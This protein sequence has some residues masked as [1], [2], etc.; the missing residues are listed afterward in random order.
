MLEGT[1]K[2][3]LFVPVIWFESGIGPGRNVGHRRFVI[4][5]DDNVDPILPI[6][7]SYTLDIV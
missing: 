1:S 5:M 7:L 3:E 2:N 4:R 6:T